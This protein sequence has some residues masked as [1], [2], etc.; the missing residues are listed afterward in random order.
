MTEKKYERYYDLASKVSYENWNSVKNSK[1]CGCYYC[2]SIFPSADVTDDDWIQ[3]LHG[4]TVLCPKCSI[5]SVIGDASG[6]PIRKDVLEE[7][8]QEKFRVEEEPIARCVGS[9]IFN[10]DTIVVREYPDG[11]AGKQFT[12]KV[13]AEE[14]GGTCGNVMCLLSEFGLETYPQASLDDSPEGKKIAEDLIQY[15]CNTRFVTHTPD[16]GTTL[17]RVTHKNITILPY[18][19]DAELAHALRSASHIIARS[20]YSTIMDL[21]ALG[22]LTTNSQLPTARI[23]LIPTPGQPEQEYLSEWLCRRSQ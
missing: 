10:L 7:L 21:E 3:D 12:E 8:Y 16:G 20:G 1:M 17:L 9:G 18:M 15:G 22:L 23:E 14:V 6:I 19:N 11:R 4:R 13:V 2:C 5:D